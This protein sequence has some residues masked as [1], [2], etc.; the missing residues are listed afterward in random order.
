MIEGEFAAFFLEVCARLGLAADG[1]R[2]TRGSVRKRIGRRLR[3]LRLAG[4]AEY[5]RYLA[6]Q[7]DEW[8]W[9]DRCCRITISRFAR[10]G[11]VYE[12]LVTRH[13]P[14]QAAAA[15][16]RGQR[17][18]R[19]WSAGSASGEEPYGLAIAWR[20]DV[21]PRFPELQLDVLATDVEPTVLAR[22]ARGGYPEGALRELPARWRVAFERRDD[23]WWL[24]EPYRAGVRFER[25]DLRSE[26]PAG[27][28]DVVLC[29][30]LA[31]TYFDEPT[32]LRLAG[33]FAAVLQPGG[34]LVVGRGERVPTGSAGLSP[35][36]P[37]LYVRSGGKC[38][39]VVPSGSA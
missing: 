8:R 23:E 12:A 32:Q 18:V 38:V 29:R 2:R 27:P 1:Y 6:A 22:A 31:F 10:D 35:N 39:P 3:E 4:L 36:E 28:Y 9:L 19:V 17:C 20:I 33:V 30:N 24:T 13:L 11:A 15:R 14:A 25:A 16:A 5:R 21:Q 26:W 34:V 37:E 7:P